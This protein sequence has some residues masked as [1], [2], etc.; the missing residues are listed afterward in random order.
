MVMLDEQSATECIYALPRGGKSIEG[1]SVWFVEIVVS[2]Y[3]N[4]HVAS[5]MVAMNHISKV[6]IAKG[7]FP[8][9]ETGSKR[10]A[11]VYHR[12]T[13]EKGHLYTTT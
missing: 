3:G 10:M 12:I 1:P 11:Q 2:Q 5:R 7:V 4:C 13:D 8:N 6:V 9:L